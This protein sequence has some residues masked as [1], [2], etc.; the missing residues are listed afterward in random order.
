VFYK[1][2]SKGFSFSYSNVIRID[3]SALTY[4][5]GG[6]SAGNWLFC[7]RKWLNP[8]D[9]ADRLQLEINYDAL[10][11]AYPEFLSC[12]K[13]IF[14]QHVADV[15]AAWTN[16]LKECDRLG[17]VRQ[18]ITSTV[19]MHFDYRSS[20]AP[21][22]DLAC[23]V[24]SIEPSPASSQSHNDW[25][26][27]LAATEDGGLRGSQSTAQQQGPVRCGDHAFPPAAKRARLDEAAEPQC[28][29]PPPRPLHE[30]WTL[31]A[32]R[33][34]APA[35]EREQG[36]L[37]GVVGRGATR[38]AE[39]A[40]WV[41]GRELPPLTAPPPGPVRACHTLWHGGGK[42]VQLKEEAVA[43]V[44]AVVAAGGGEAGPSDARSGP[45]AL[46]QGASPRGFGAWKPCG[47]APKTP[48]WP[49]A[50]AA[51]AAGEAGGARGPRLPT[52]LGE[53]DSEGAGAQR[54]WASPHPP[55]VLRPVVKRPVEH[56]PAAAAPDGG[57]WA[58]VSAAAAACRAA[59]AAM[60][61]G[62]D[63]A[64]SPAMEEGAECAPSPA[65]EE[66]P[67]R[68]RS[69]ACGRGDALPAAGRGPGAGLGRGAGTEKAAIAGWLEGLG[70]GMYL[71]LLLR[72]GW[73]S[74]EVRWAQAGM[75]WLGHAPRQQWP[76]VAVMW[77]RWDSDGV[78]RSCRR[79][80]RRAP[81]PRS[82]GA[83]GECLAAS[84]AADEG[85]RGR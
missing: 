28:T 71:D 52:T 17:F 13:P 5:L 8:L 69:A 50:S 16:R 76:G 68:T 45:G 67:A 72:E 46:G 19:A 30:P 58:A 79:Q 77:P 15:A 51:R 84:R 60:E 80:W 2:R 47:P 32:G 70:L 59:L 33:P 14:I 40:V 49:L 66:G 24:T 37:G 74:V 10:S 26:A 41:G 18:P 21:S 82:R 39:T 9:L 55:G 36:G 3:G 81:V 85:A 7:N 83:R 78:G 56:K 31:P 11:G 12:P 57:A 27:N 44:G 63:C 23:C 75:G 38:Q 62:T 48:L 43:V 65:M 4:L 1:V 53:E 22:S 34:V 20:I 6:S 61:E 73:D 54:V 64:P 29:A 42:A 35:R 25:G